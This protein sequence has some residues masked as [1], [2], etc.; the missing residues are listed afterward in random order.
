MRILFKGPRGAADREKPAPITFG[1]LG[2]IKLTPGQEADVPP[3]VGRILVQTNQAVEVIASRED[4]A[5]EIANFKKRVEEKKKE[6]EE[7][8]TKSDRQ[9]E[10]PKRKRRSL[11]QPTQSE[12]EV[13]KPLADETEE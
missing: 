12:E 13:G 7:K 1:R 9:E 5:K 11:F 2:G 3:R 8:S 10:R 4:T 6:E